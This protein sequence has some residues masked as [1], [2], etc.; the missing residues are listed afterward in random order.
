M[1]R[2]PTTRQMSDAHEIHVCELL[3]M[4]R[5]KASG[6]QFND[7]MDG[8]HDEGAWRFAMDGKA[9]L[10]KSIGVSRE[11]WDKAIEQ[12]HGARPLIP[13]R[14]Y[15]DWRLTPGLD[16]VVADLNDLAELIERVR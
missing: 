12:S 11:M 7:Q 3:G 2:R 16:L 1:A 9:T 14:F 5:T 10:G 8:R 15:D 6:S 13:L 4:R